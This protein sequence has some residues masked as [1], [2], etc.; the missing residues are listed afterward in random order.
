MV[1][2]HDRRCPSV[3][4][5]RGASDRTKGATHDSRIPSY[6]PYHCSRARNHNRALVA[7]GESVIDAL[8]LSFLG[9][10]LALLTAV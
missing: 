7:Q 10:L 4:Q 2:V 1:E 5:G 6:R 8:P 3:G 9:L